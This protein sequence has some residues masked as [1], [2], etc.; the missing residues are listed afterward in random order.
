MKKFLLFFLVFCMSF[1]IACNKTDKPAEENEMLNY[2]EYE[3]DEFIESNKNEGKSQ[4]FAYTYKEEEK[5]IPSEEETSKEEQFIDAIKYLEVQKVKELI[6]KGIDVNFTKEERK[7]ISGFGP[8]NDA[9]EMIIKTPLTY[10]LER[11]KNI[12]EDIEGLKKRLEQEKADAL[13]SQEEWQAKYGDCIV[14][15]GPNPD[16]CAKELKEAQDKQ[17]VITEIIKLLKAAGAK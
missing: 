17:K 12:K 13:L 4:S 1:I 10:A 5:E 2:E 9:Y 16:Q 15:E 3:E 6:E 11:E 8:T 7:W 14:C